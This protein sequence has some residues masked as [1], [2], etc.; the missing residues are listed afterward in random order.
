MTLLYTLR[1]TGCLLP[2]LCSANWYKLQRK[3]GRRRQI[4]STNQKPDMLCDTFNMCCT[5]LLLQR[6]S[7]CFIFVIFRF[8]SMHMD[9][10]GS[11][12]SLPELHELSLFYIL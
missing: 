4:H 6:E 1:L 2:G 3:E 5:S 11:I 9:S 8:L 10:E 12:E 7:F